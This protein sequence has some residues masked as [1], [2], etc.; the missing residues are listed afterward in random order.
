[1]AKRENSVYAGI[2]NDIESKIQS[3]EYKQGTLLPPER[4]L[5][6]MYKVERTTIRRALEILTQN[7]L[8]VKKAGL[9]NLVASPDEIIVAKDDVS[10]AVTAKPGKKGGLVICVGSF[11]EGKCAFFPVIKAFENLCRKNGYTFSYVSPYDAATLKKQIS[12][13]NCLGA[14]ITEKLTNDAEK[15]LMDSKTPCIYAFAK[16]NGRSVCPDVDGAMLSLMEA[17]VEKGHK[18]I[19]FIGSDEKLF[20]KSITGASLDYDSSLTIRCGVDEQGGY[21]AFCA[22]QRRMSGRFTAVFA[23]SLDAAKGIL[24][25]CKDLDIEVP[26]QLSVACLSYENDSD[27]TCAVFDKNMLAQEILF[28]LENEAESEYP[29]ACTTLMGYEIHG[30]TIGTAPGSRR[31]TMSDFLL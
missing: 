9:G 17:L 28:A 22:L 10:T 26:R 30:D 2:A 19:S 23:E 18:K 12:S 13:N 25:T 3:G 16:G 8:V 14:V 24:K 31:S 11:S 29:T 1:M 21:D 5:K 6:E 15:A 4:V 7:G 20:A 27:I